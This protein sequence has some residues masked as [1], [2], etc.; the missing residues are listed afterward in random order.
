MADIRRYEPLVLAVACI[1]PTLVTLVYFVWAA[2]S[3]SDVQQAVYVAAKAVQFALPVVWVAMTC[4]ERLGW[5]RWTYNGLQW[6][7]V[8]GAMV[9]AA[10]YLLYTLLSGA[11]LLEQAL[12]P[13][14]EKIAGMGVATPGRFLTL[15]LFYALFHSLLEEYYWRWFVFDRLKQHIKLGPAI[16]VSA[17]AFAAHHVV[18]LWAYFAHAWWMVVLL[19]VAVAIG[20]AFW[21]WLYHRSGSMWAIWISHLLVDAGIFAVGYHVAAPMFAN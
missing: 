2:G 21:A 20:G 16:V 15:G 13:I 10:T 6:G 14:R 11:P 19:A 5:P 1:L 17:V 4:R 7:V 12:D 3:T 18:V 8:F 9:F